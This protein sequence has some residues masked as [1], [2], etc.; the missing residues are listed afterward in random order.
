MDPDCG[1]SRGPLIIRVASFR[2]PSRR[3]AMRKRLLARYLAIS[4][5]LHMLREV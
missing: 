2:V 5:P 1:A 3:V 4:L